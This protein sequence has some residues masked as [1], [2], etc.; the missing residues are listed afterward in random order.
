[1]RW[2]VVMAVLAPG[3][4]LAQDPV[5]DPAQTRACLA[6]AR[7]LAEQRMCIGASADVCIT[8]TPAGSTTL[9]MGFCIHEEMKF[10]DAR[11][12]DTY[13]TLRAKERETDADMAGDRGAPSRAETLRDMQR[14][15]IAFRDATCAYERSQWGS[16]TGG[17]PAQVSCLMR[18]TAEQA[19]YLDG[20]L[21]T[22]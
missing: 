3:A 16:G 18:L 22:W 9:G 2:L 7:G 10:W 21:E 19:L 14:T 1:M 11:L 13:R 20:M 5:F 15:W 8:G 6:E 17:G 12:N 4:A